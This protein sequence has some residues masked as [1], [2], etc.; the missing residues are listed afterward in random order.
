MSWLHRYRRSPGFLPLW[1]GRPAC[2]GL[3]RGGQRPAGPLCRPEA[4]TTIV[5]S[6]HRHRRSPGLL[7]LWCGRP[8]CT[9]L[10][11]GGQRPAG[12][13]CRPEARTT[14]VS[15]LHRHRRSPGLLPLW[16]GRPACTGL[17]R[18]GQRPAGPLCRPEAHTTKY[19]RCTGI[20]VLPVF[21]PCGAGVP[22]ARGC[23]G[24]VSGPPGRYA[25]RRPTP[26]NIFAAPVSPFSRFSSVVVRASRLHGVAAGRSAA[27]RAAMQAGG[28]HHNNIFAAPVS[29]FS[30]SS[31]LVVRASR[32]HGV[33]AGGVQRDH[34]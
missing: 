25:G 24:E 22:P 11:R 23:G 31:S 9:G 19:L 30:R 16:C 32:L 4:R 21:F 20:A 6:L 2:T 3:R 33:A 1:C 8:A 29:P 10:R 7:P 17:R 15:S 18:G 12:P 14:I 26:Q 28:P 5:S 13:L 27:R 34:D